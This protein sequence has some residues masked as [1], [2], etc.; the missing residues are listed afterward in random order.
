MR[1][2][3]Q[4]GNLAYSYRRQKDRPA[5]RGINLEIQR[6]EFVAIAGR[7]GS[8]KSTLCY[9]LNGLIPH[10]FGGKFDGEVIVCGLNTRIASVPQLARHVG[11]VMQNAESQLVGLS[12]EEDAAFGP[13]NLGL[14]SQDVTLRVQHALRVVRLDTNLKR[15][16]WS[17]SGGQKQRLSIAAAVAIQPQVLVLDNPTAE[18]DPVGKE[19]VMATLGQLNLE[20]GITVV[21]VNQELEEILPYATRL[22]LMNEGQILCTGSTAEVIDQANNI[23]RAGVRLPEIA[24]VADALRSRGRWSAKLPITVEEAVKQLRHLPSAR[25][26]NFSTNPA[27]S[28]SEM[29]IQMEDVSFAYSDGRC[30]LHNATFNVKRGEFVTLMGPNAAGKTTLAKLM[31]GLL[32]PTAGR[33]LV[34]GNDTAVTRLAE[35]AKTVG[36]VFQNPDHQLFARTIKEEL[37]FGPRN[38]GW[39]K[40][41]VDRAVQRGLEHI[42]GKSRGD[43]DPFFLGLAERKLVS[44]ASVLA[45]GPQ[46]LLLDEPATGADHEAALRI[47]TYLA[48][49]HR[50]GLTIVI[51][52]HDVS[53]AARYADR[54]VVMRSGSIVLD[55]TPNRV[56]RESGLLRECSVIPPPAAQL[57]EKLALPDFTCRIDEIVERFVGAS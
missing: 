33:V 13:E 23:H 10:S 50:Q 25:A 5:L 16:P 29:M 12:V 48:D 19:E 15:S 18:L 37:A 22:V 55:G 36:Y 26:S 17:L 21:I 38:L 2:I 3:I 32:T 44:I 1:P 4:I 11:F 56:F 27:V 46:I 40:A 8:G 20:F 57:A 47:M 31:N 54:I 9:A 45:M 53:L 39:T 49:L 35:L 6:G 52:T 43:N 51:V 28:N 14:P 24:Q 41:E 42:G 7:A 34:R 30:V